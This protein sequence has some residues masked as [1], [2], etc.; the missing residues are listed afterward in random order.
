ML[1]ITFEYEGQLASADSFNVTAD[2]SMGTPDF[3]TSTK[4]LWSETDSIYIEMDDLD[5]YFIKGFDRL[6]IWG[7]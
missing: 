1:N 7:G 2:Y 6:L 3:Y 4:L 5:P